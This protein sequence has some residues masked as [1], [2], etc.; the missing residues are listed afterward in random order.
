[1][2]KENTDKNVYGEWFN[3]VKIPDNELNKYKVIFIYR[4]PID[5][6]FSRFAQPNGPNIPHLQHIMCD[7]NGNINLF[8][9]LKSGKDLYGLEEFY[10]NYTS[11]K[12]RNY[13]IYCVKYELFWNNIST[14]N[15]IMEIP[16]IKELYP[17]KV[18][19][20]KKLQ[21]VANLNAIYL[22]LIYKMSK[23]PFIELVRPLGYVENKYITNE[24]EV[25]E[26]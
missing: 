16:N 9:V 3:G 8:D 23:K 17:M 21:F 22:S 4:H 25:E 19:R 5:V 11:C 15:K 20:K 6:I 14:F 12:E 18:E 1:V 24:T 10:D 13:N 2:G 7:N 26:K